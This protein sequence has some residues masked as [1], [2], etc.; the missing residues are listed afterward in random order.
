MLDEDGE[1]SVQPAETPAVRTARMLGYA[2]LAPFAILS[3]WLLGIAPDHEWRAGTILLLVVYAAVILSFLGGARWGLALADGVD[4]SPAVFAASIVPPLVA[5][6]AAAM[7]PP[8]CFALLAVAFAAHG[9]WDT[10]AVHQMKAPEWYGR[11]RTVLTIG[12]VATMLVAFA[13]TS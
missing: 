10:L 13:A 3:L 7:P 9:A 8:Y 4:Q 11:M 2:G 6:I 1:S 5:W 12:V